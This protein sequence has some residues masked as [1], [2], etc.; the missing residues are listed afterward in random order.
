M[1]SKK[2]SVKA[3][4]SPTFSIT[5]AVPFYKEVDQSDERLKTLKDFCQQWNAETECYLID[6]TSEKQLSQ[7]LSDSEIFNNLQESCSASIL[8]GFTNLGAGLKH[9]AEQANGDYFLY[10]SGSHEVKPQKVKEWASQ[11]KEGFPK[12]AIFTGNRISGDKTARKQILSQEGKGHAWFHGFSTF[13]IEDPGNPIKLYPLKIAKYLFQQIPDTSPLFENEALHQAQ[14]DGIAIHEFPSKTKGK[15]QEKSRAEAYYGSPPSRLQGLMRAIAFKWNHQIKQPVTGL[16]GKTQPLD[17]LKN[18]QYGTRLAF[19]LI[20]IGLFLAMPLLSFDYGATGDE[21]IQDGYGKKVVNFYTSLGQDQS[22]TSYKGTYRYGGLFEFFGSGAANIVDHY[23]E[24][25][26]RY[27]TRHVINALFGFLIF[28][29]GGLLGRYFGGWRGGLLVLLFLILS[30]RLFGHAFN[31][32]K[33]IPFAAAYLMGVY[34]LIKFLREFPN[35]TKRAMTWLIVAIAFSIN[36]RV[37]GLLLICYFGL[38]GLLELGKQFYGNGLSQPER[39]S[40]FNKAVRYGLIVIILGYF[41]GTLFWPYALQNPIANPFNALSAMSDYPVNITILFEGDQ[42]KSR[43]IP[44]HYIF[45]Y[46]WITT[47]LFGLAGF[48]LFLLGTPKIRHF[49]NAF[50]YGIIL[51][52]VVFPIAYIIYLGS[53]LYDGIRQVLFIYPPIIVLSGLAFHHLYDTLQNRYAKWG[54]TAVLVILMALPLNFMAKNHPN[55]YVY[56]NEIQGGVDEAFGNYEMDYWGQSGKQAAHW[57]GKEINPNGELDSNIQFRANFINST[58]PVLKRYSDSFGGKYASFRNRSKQQWDYAIFIARFISPTILENYWPPQGTVHEV[59]VDGQPISVVIKRPNN[60][61][62]QGFQHLEKQQFRAAIEDFEQYV[63][64]DPYN[65]NVLSGLGRCYLQTKQINQAQ[66]TLEQA[67]KINN[68]DPMALMQLGQIHYQKR[69]PRRALEYF[70]ALRRVNPRLYRR[71]QKL[72]K[73]AR[74]MMRQQ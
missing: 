21:N 42:I 23:T 28:L 49:K 26:Y 54:L 5:I 52:A 15:E 30:P 10:W 65:A 12:D 57:L 11:Y 14:M 69:E 56:F 71:A 66:E 38:F 48:G 58:R 41:G 19:S 50:Y 1:A 18:P 59:K 61:D 51:F 33:D 9:S 73:R 62:Y 64:A 2:S 55:E 35:P 39:T 36:I 46:L 53:N 60:H 40:R 37:G 3:S 43:N 22:A 29:F 17:F 45:K 25:N 68:S 16:T 4:P 74:Q 6:L 8:N 67:L 32:P 31:N 47:P 72:V 70:N 13:R 63:E 20:L 34:F 44:W 24:D 27:E 7:N